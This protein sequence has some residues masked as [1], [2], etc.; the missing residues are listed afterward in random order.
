MK[1]YST[2]IENNLESHTRALQQITRLRNEDIGDWNNLANT[3]VSGRKVGR[4]P[5]SSVDVIDGDRVGDINY[6]LN[7]LYL[8]S[9]DGVTPAWRRIALAA[10]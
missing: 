1:S 2:L 6:D 10:W 4:V 9:T 7:Y 3:Y 5:S 8:L